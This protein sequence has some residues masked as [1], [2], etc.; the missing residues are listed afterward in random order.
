MNLADVRAGFVSAGIPAEL[1]DEVLD[2]Y[3]ETKRRF[4]L[5]DHRPTAVEGGR[6]C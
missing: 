2:Q 1:A 6:F 3:V 4:Y 5:D